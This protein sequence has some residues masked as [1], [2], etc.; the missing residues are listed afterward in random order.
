L[1]RSATEVDGRPVGEPHNAAEGS[2]DYLEE[3]EN[4]LKERKGLN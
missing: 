4:R 2:Q 3:V 1:Q